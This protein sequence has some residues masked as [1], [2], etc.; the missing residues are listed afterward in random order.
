MKD[1]DR[2]CRLVSEDVITMNSDTVAI[3]VCTATHFVYYEISN[4]YS[5]RKIKVCTDFVNKMFF[6]SI[7]NAELI[8]NFTF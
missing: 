2:T 3:F 6:L 7:I 5:P 1:T 4:V 8:L